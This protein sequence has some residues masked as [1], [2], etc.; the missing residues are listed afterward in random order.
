MILKMFYHHSSQVRNKYE[1]DEMM[2]AAEYFLGPRWDIRKPT[3]DNSF[4]SF[5]LHLVQLHAAPDAH[6]ELIRRFNLPKL[7]KLTILAERKNS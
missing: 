6:I 7:T 5:T 2:A 1:L 3:I 4:K